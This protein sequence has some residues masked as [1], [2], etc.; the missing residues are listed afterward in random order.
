MKHDEIIY[1]RVPRRL[2]KAL[3]RERKCRSV[4]TGAEVKTSAVIRALLEHA[5][6]GPQKNARA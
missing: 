6:F 3:E 4:A 2:R 1:A 5:L